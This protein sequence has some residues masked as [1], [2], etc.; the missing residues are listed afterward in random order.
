MLLATTYWLLHAPFLLIVLI[1]R[2]STFRV[3][4][5]IKC[6]ESENEVLEKNEKNL[7]ES[8]EVLLQSRE[9]FIK[10]YE[11][12]IYPVCSALSLCVSWS[13]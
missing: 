10:R 11:A 6:L 8:M 13:L 1:F 5:Q 2:I 7:K 3:P 12:G 4:V 9:A